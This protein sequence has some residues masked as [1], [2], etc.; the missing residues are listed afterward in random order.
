MTAG[1]A[2]ARLVEAASRRGAEYADARWVEREQESVSVKDGEVEGV[3]RSSD[4]GIGFRVLVRGAWGFAATDRTSEAAL[5]S[6]VDAAFQR[7]EASATTRRVPVRLAPQA[8]QRGSY[9]TPLR[10]DPFGVPSPA[11]APTSSRS[12]STPR[13]ASRSWR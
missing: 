9:R 5:R 10:R 2:L 13:R 8:P 3:E 11:T 4:R 12:S 7:A 6:L 1:A